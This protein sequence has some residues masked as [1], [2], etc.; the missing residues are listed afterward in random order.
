MLNTPTR[1]RHRPRAFWKVTGARPLNDGEAV[2]DVPHKVV[3]IL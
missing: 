1:F 2:K 3:D